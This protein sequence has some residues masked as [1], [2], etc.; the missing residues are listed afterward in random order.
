MTRKDLIKIVKRFPKTAQVKL[1]GNEPTIRAQVDEQG[2]WSIIIE[3]KEDKK[4]NEISENN[5]CQNENN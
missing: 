1:N 4:I 5:S 3:N 2:N